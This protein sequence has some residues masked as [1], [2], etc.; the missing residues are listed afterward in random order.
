MAIEVI[1]QPRK[2][3]GTGASRRLRREGWVPGVV[4]GGASEPATIEI[5]HNSLFH[6]LQQEQ[7]HAS[8][9]SLKVDDSAEQVLLRAVNMHP[10]KQQV[11]HVD[12]QRVLPDQKIHLKV[13]IHFKNA[14]Q[15]DAVKFG[16]AI[17]SHVLNEIDI[18]CLPAH[19][20]AF[21]EV[22]LATIS[23]GHSIHVSDLQLP[24]GV[25][26]AVRRG[27]NPAVATAQVPRAAAADEE[28]AADK[29]APAASAVPAAKQPDKPDAGKDGAAKVGDKGGAAKAGGDKKK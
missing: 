4:Y 8:I 20:P 29:E 22:D 18:R 27:E 10:W 21:I 26:V 15:S 28:A 25:E 17:V 11:Q 6:Q 14:E 13:P 19:L 24:E 9:L 12:F 7:F 23:A 16:G 3:Q 5:D 1:A 2:L